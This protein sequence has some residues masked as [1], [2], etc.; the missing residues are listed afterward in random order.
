MSAKGM[1]NSVSPDNVAVQVL[2]G[3]VDADGNL[4]DPVVI[5]MRPSERSAAGAYLF[6]TVI[7]HSA[8]SVLHG[9]AIRQFQSPQIPSIRFNQA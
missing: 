9:Y 3:L 4:K 1:R 8:R 6:Q 7:Q 5:P 2:T